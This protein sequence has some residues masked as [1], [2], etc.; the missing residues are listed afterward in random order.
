M[1]FVLLRDTRWG[2]LTADTAN[3][4]LRALKYY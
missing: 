2:G 3:G 1:Q 4:A